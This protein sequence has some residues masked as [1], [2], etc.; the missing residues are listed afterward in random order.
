MLGSHVG[1]R[2]WGGP[3]IWLTDRQMFAL[4]GD[5]MSLGM[6]GGGG[7][8]RYW[9]KYAKKAKKPLFR[10]Y[11]SIKRKIFV[12]QYAQQFKA[13]CWAVIID[14]LY[15]IYTFRVLWLANFIAVKY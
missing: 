14:S 9:N 3:E 6:G 7:M 5:S 12:K 4:R 2:G 15:F 8:A 10:R 13:F 11:M 1:G